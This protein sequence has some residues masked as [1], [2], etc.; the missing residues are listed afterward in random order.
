MMMSLKPKTKS[1]RYKTKFLNHMLALPLLLSLKLVSARS[2]ECLIFKK[3][4]PAFVYPS[5]SSATTSTGSTSAP[6]LVPSIVRVSDNDHPHA[7]HN[8]SR[9][10]RNIHTRTLKTTSA[11]SAKKKKGYQFGDLTKGLVNSVTGKSEYKF[12]DLSK[13]LDQQAKTRIAELHNKTTYEVGDLS[14]YLD[15]SAKQTLSEWTEK[16]R[17][18]FGDVTKAILKKVSERDYTFSDL[19]LLL[20]TLMSFG[21]GMSS[22]SGF[23]PM[24]LLIDLLNYSIIGDLGQKVVSAIAEEIDKRMKHALTGDENYAVGDLTKREILKYV[25]KEKGEDEYEFGD[26]TKTVLKDYEARKESSAAGVISSSME[27]NQMESDS[28][29][30]IDVNAVEVDKEG[31]SIVKP[32]LGELPSEMSKDFDFLDNK[33][34]LDNEKATSN[35]SM[36]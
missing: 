18:A 29:F 4:P 35:E 2:G 16:E 20:K 5:S 34:S 12:G 6:P 28:S 25:G 33:M 30:V 31:R 21:V 15:R 10:I 14:R 23:L 3:G 13:H 7:S 26:I 9:S 27:R 1:I 22:V 17:Y 19:V 8:P 24:K 11:L 32:F 36:K